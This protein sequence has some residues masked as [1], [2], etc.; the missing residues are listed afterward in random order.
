ML[1]CVLGAVPPL[2]VVAGAFIQKVLRL[3]IIDYL[4]FYGLVAWNLSP[5]LGVLWLTLM[6]GRRRTG[7]IAALIVSIAV[8]L[9]MALGC[10]WY[11]LNRSGQ[12]SGL[13]LFVLPIPVWIAPGVAG[14]VIAL[15]TQA[16]AT[17]RSFTGKQSSDVK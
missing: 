8:A 13:V 1:V 17:Y 3:E 14:V 10:I 6:L 9:Y 7:A 15:T 2:V 12:L 4:I 11:L 5:F 16:R